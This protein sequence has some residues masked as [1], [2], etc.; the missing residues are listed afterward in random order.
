[1]AAFSSIALA[2]GAAASVVGTVSSIRA[3]K[4]QARAQQKQQ[5][6]QHRQSQRQAVRQAQ[7]QR[8]SLVAGAAGAGAGG[9]SGA[10]G[11]I[12]GITSPL[13]SALGYGTQMSALSGI[14]STQAQKAANFNAL[15]SLGG[16]LMNYGLSSPHTQNLVQGMFTPNK[17]AQPTPDFTGPI[18][19]YQ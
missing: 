9:S 10:A 1:M 15:S 7:I 18:P 14:I 3:Q 2:V 11:G 8:A 4:K 12:G 19:R 6:L 17:A 16:S 13:G 5:T